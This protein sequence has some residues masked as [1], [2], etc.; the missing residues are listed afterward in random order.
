MKSLS[1]RY[2]RSR[3]DN[4]ETERLDIKHEEFKVW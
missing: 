3:A 4:E 2:R 1:V